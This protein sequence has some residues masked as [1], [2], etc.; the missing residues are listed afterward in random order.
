MSLMSDGLNDLFKAIGEK[1]GG[2]AAD[3]SGVDPE[4]G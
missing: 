4:K 2:I 1:L 3:V